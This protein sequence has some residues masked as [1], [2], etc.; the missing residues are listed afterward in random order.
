MEKDS[1]CEIDR[2]REIEIVPRRD[3]RVRKIERIR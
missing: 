3:E 2:E 1:V